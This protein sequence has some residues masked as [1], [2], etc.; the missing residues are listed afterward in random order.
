MSLIYIIFI[1][2]VAYKTW[3]KKVLVML[4]WNRWAMYFFWSFTL[5]RWTAL[6][7]REYNIFIKKCQKA[8]RI[9]GNKKKK[10]MRGGN[11]NKLLI[12]FYGS[13]MSRIL[14]FLFYYILL[15]FSRLSKK[16]FFFCWKNYVWPEFY[17]Y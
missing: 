1:S 4:T 14:L 11:G 15:G 16:K 6:H 12:Y 10:N 2:G 17:V 7:E 3:Q 13:L 9:L 5:A 8:E